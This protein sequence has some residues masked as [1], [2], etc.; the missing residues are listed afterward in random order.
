MANSV[1]ARGRFLPKKSSYAHAH[2]SL[3]AC[4]V[5]YGQAKL[6]NASSEQRQ[7]SRCLAHCMH[8]KR[9]PRSLFIEIKASLPGF[10]YALPTRALNPRSVISCPERKEG[11]K[12][13]L[14]ALLMDPGLLQCQKKRLEAAHSWLEK[15]AKRVQ[16]RGCRPFLLLQNVRF[17]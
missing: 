7:A 9:G 15:D 8:L 12:C 1:F 17:S 2:S 14:T 10:I 6:K 11:N 3:P 16:Y 5:G 13:G 4:M